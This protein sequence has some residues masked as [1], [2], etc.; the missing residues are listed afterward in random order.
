MRLLSLRLVNYRKY[1]SASVEFAD[2]IMGIVGKN[3]AGKSTLIEAIGWC[4]YGS[5]ASR[6]LQ[7]EIVTTGAARGTACSVTLEVEMGGETVTIVRE[8]KAGQAAGTARLYEQGKSAARVTGAKEVTDYVSSRLRMDNVAFFSSIFARQKELTALSDMVPS[9]KHMIISRLLR[10]DT[11][12]AAIQMIKSDKKSQLD[13]I[14]GLREGA[15]DIR[16]AKSRV[17]SLEKDLRLLRSDCEAASDDADAAK[18]LLETA[19][20]G[21]EKQEKTKDKHNRHRAS[22]E[23]AW[24]VREAKVSDR[25]AARDE[26]AELEKARGRLESLAP[27]IADYTKTKEK[28]GELDKNAARYAEKKAAEANVDGARTDIAA[29]EDILA[30]WRSSIAA[31]LPALLGVD[32]LDTKLGDLEKRLEAAHAAKSRAEVQADEARKRA[33]AKKQTA[34][35]LKKLGRRAACPTC[36]RLLGED[37]AEIAQGLDREISELGGAADG[38]EADAD[39]AGREADTLR[40]AIDV[41]GE[42]ARAAGDAKREIERLQ[43]LVE[44]GE[45]RATSLRA[46]MDE[47]EKALAKFSGL[48]YDENEHNLLRESLDRLEKTHEEAARLEGRTGAIPDVSGRIKKLDKEIADQEAA[49]GRAERAMKKTG[50]DESAHAA[51]KL[52]RDKMDEKH[53]AARDALMSLRGDIKAAKADLSHAK[54]TVSEEEERARKIARMEKEHEALGRLETIMASFKSDLASRI[55]PSLS[56]RSSDLMRRM[57]GGKYSTV[58]LDD[59]YNMSIESDGELFKTGRFSGGEQDLASLCLRIA[60][61]QELSDRAGSAGPNFIVLDEVFGSQDSERKPAILDALSGLL[62][63]FRQIILITHIEDVKDALPYALHVEEA[64]DGASAITIEGRPAPWGVP[65]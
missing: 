3:G 11:V 2:G 62:Q 48:S 18:E 6:S 4:L 7:S 24:S 12:D 20:A 36:N 61:S 35:H 8:L 53:R 14:K 32:K 60:I 54:E 57:T 56:A 39:K 19:K 23:S 9:Q 30:E 22:L 33:A 43:S 64:H 44:E 52:L 27:D 58:S 65:P 10:I 45:E 63:E 31:Q 17:L 40:S 46:S 1:R 29:Q 38:Y 49:A 15:A 34:A 5:P 13:R 50:F 21:L 28:V 26:L 51:A 37:F 47:H 41:T 25:S 16:E 42:C 55:R 59:S